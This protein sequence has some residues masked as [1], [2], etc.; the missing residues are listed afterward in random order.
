[1]ESTY[2]VGESEGAADVLMWTAG[3]PSYEIMSN[4]VVEA[5]LQHARTYYVTVGTVNGAGSPV[6]SSV[7]HPTTI[8]LTVP[9]LH[10]ASVEARTSPSGAFYWGATVA[11]PLDVNATDP[12]S[13]IDHIEVTVWEVA[14]HPDAYLQRPGGEVVP[15]TSLGAG[16][17]SHASGFEAPLVGGAAYYMRVRALNAAGSLSEEHKSPIFLVD[18]T[19]PVC[20]NGVGDGDGSIAFDLEFTNTMSTVSAV[21][22][23][24]DPESHISSALWA[25]R[26]VPSGDELVSPQEVGISPSGE[27]SVA[28][29]HRDV[30][31]AR[32]EVTNGAG[33]ATPW[34]LSDNVLYDATPPAN[35][36]VIG[37]APSVDELYFR[38]SGYQHTTDKLQIGVTGFNDPESG[39]LRCD[40]GS[41]CV[42]N[43][44][45]LILDGTRTPPSGTCNSDE[46]AELVSKLQLLPEELEH[47]DVC[48]TR[49]SVT[50]RARSVTTIVSRAVMV[51]T[52]KPIIAG[53]RARP[54]YPPRNLDELLLTT[55]TVE[56]VTIV[57]SL[58][59]AFDPESGLESMSWTIWNGPDVLL[60]E[61]TRDL[62]G[63]QDS[64]LTYTVTNMT[65]NITYPVTVTM[66]LL[67]RA[68]NEAVK[69]VHFPVKIFDLR[70]GVV[71]DTAYAHLLDRIPDRMVKVPDYGFSQTY[72]D[73]PTSVVAAWQGFI[74]PFANVSFE[75]GVCMNE[76]AW[77][78]DVMDVGVGGIV[79]WPLGNGVAVS[80]GAMYGV[81]RFKH[82][83]RYQVIVVAHDSAN[84]AETVNDTST[85][86]VIDLTPPTFA[87]LNDNSVWVVQESLD[88]LATP[89]NPAAIAA[90]VRN[91]TQLSTPPA[92][93]TWSANDTE[94]GL[95]T[96]VVRVGREMRG[97]DLMNETYFGAHTRSLTLDNV[98]TG[99]PVS[100]GDTVFATVQTRN[101]A[102]RWAEEASAVITLDSTPPV[103]TVVAAHVN[104][105][106]VLEP[107]RPFPEPGSWSN[108]SSVVHVTYLSSD[109][110]GAQ[111]A[112]H[113]SESLIAWQQW[114]IGTQPKLCDVVDWTTVA[115]LARE[116]FVEDM[117]GL[118]ANFI[119]ENAANTVSF[120]VS[121]R[122]A[123]A[124]GLMTL[125]HSSPVVV[126]TTPPISLCP[127]DEPPE[128]EPVPSGTWPRTVHGYRIQY[129]SNPE[130]MEV[131]YGVELGS[132]EENPKITLSGRY[133]RTNHGQWTIFGEPITGKDCTGGKQYSM[134]DW[135]VSGT[136]C[137]NWGNS[138]GFYR[139]TPV[140]H[141]ATIAVEFLSTAVPFDVYLVDENAND[142][143]R[144]PPDTAN[145]HNGERA[146]VFFLTNC[147]FNYVPPPPEPV[148]VPSN[149]SS[150]G[151]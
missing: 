12:E 55:T 7:A 13:P 90:A 91:H 66:R 60:V 8:D 10:V 80:A 27:R 99:E 39:L 59:D 111:W 88:P 146:I 52:T 101:R 110:L 49:V 26:H 126:D 51:D 118:A 140:T 70:P 149:H 96:T 28:V 109:S 74:K 86:V 46:E 135:R 150:C 93:I 32:A 117:H 133:P 85:G 113:D 15:W 68:N 3:P 23:C 128:P 77:N 63:A 41:W 20:T 31:Q 79:A 108:T 21:W 43:G 83:D 72:T 124:L 87:T 105:S 61:E 151:K 69:S 145:Q 106:G 123:N 130:V 37:M 144:C 147:D 4:P 44:T 65:L 116:A 48:Y 5:L 71:A 136:Y 104:A 125:A 138:H 100:H 35:G 42:R 107:L 143:V 17:A 18:D 103:V 81:E 120:Y 131:V 75:W 95:L 50:N 36:S 92:T 139:T 9:L 82:G 142:I 1:M 122:V 33:L 40:Y 132:V 127:V 84:P 24:V 97:S 29:N 102:G 30:V 129:Q 2:A 47:K 34:M 73:D 11:L 64:N 112:A 14:N 134:W 6:Y 148:V 16:V 121:V 67:N 58:A 53:L 78:G 94:S 76:C 141:G 19:P 115:P 56:N 38:E 119:P 45:E 25:A 22:D 89:W 54:I 137:S 114:C 98:T 62:N 57:V